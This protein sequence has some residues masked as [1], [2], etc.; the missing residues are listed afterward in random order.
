MA[1]HNKS[2]KT[3][4]IDIPLDPDP[5]DLNIIRKKDFKQV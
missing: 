5:K 3:K 4:Y 1:F 2:K